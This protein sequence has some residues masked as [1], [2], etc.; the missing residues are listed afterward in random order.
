MGIAS[1]GMT[2]MGNW[3][4]KLPDL[5]VVGRIGIGMICWHLE[6]IPSVSLEGFGAGI[7]L[8]VAL[9]SASPTVSVM[10]T[11]GTE[12]GEGDMMRQLVDEEVQ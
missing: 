1:S 2:T 10:P 4:G 12:G 11:I 7:P 5:E 8:E 6:G 3:E 9:V